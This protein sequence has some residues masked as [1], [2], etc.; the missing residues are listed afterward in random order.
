[1]QTIII[2][3][4]SKEMDRTSGIE[5][6]LLSTTSEYIYQTIRYMNLNQ[7]QDILSI[8]HQKAITVFD[9]YAHLLQHTAKAAI[10]TYDGIAYRQLDTDKLDPQF[11]ENHLVI[12][13]AFY[14]PITALTPIN[15]YRLDFTSKI[16]I[17]NQTLKRLWKQP[18]NDFLQDHHVI[19]LASKEFSDII[20]L[21]QC[22]LW[23]VEFYAD[24]TLTKRAPSATVKKL[25]GALTH[26]LLCHQDFSELC[27]KKFKFDMYSLH[28]ID[29][30]NKR[31]I[32]AK[33]SVH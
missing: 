14:G 33:N 16:K 8:N 18:F 17:N 3:S 30:V 1:M 13:S 29:T 22:H 19:N 12:L 32:Y 7:L 11:I 15:P 10:N 6:P 9:D 20:N 27:F 25:R 23:Q 2:I 24:Q 31:Y 28:S 4:P 5:A 21:N 26:H